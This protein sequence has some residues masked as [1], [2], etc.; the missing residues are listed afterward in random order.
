MNQQT[1]SRNRLRDLYRESTMG[2]A[3]DYAQLKRR[4]LDLSVASAGN[5]RAIDKLLQRLQ[6]AS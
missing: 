4:L 3:A 1:P 5:T 2:L 6:A